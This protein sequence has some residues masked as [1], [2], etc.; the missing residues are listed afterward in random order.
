MQRIEHIYTAVKTSIVNT[1]NAV[2]DFVTK[3]K[4]IRIFVGLIF[5]FLSMLFSLPVKYFGRLLMLFNIMK[6]IDSL[7][8]LNGDGKRDDK[9]NKQV[10]RLWIIYTVLNL[11]THLTTTYLEQYT[12]E[13]AVNLSIM[14]VYYTMLNNSAN[15]VEGCINFV[16]RFYYVN[17]VIMDRYIELISGGCKFALNTT[18][19]VGLLCGN[20]FGRYVNLNPLYYVCRNIKRGTLFS[21]NQTR[22]LVQKL[23]NRRTDEVANVLIVAEQQN[24]IDQ[25]VNRTDDEELPTSDVVDQSD[26]PHIHDSTEQTNVVDQTNTLTDR[27]QLAPTDGIETVSLSVHALDDT[28][29]TPDVDLITLSEPTI[30]VSLT[31][32]PEYVG[33]EDEL[34]ETF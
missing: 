15:V 17:I 25:P 22:T 9:K 6:T 29:V 27:N 18:A 31:H 26:Q 16:T 32:Q 11:V 7:S 1:Y 20:V 5:T 4:Y 12:C 28:T 13:Y 2:V 33:Y 23:K 19:D 10:H 34:D 3:V 30:S 24:V 8:N 21:I 14:F